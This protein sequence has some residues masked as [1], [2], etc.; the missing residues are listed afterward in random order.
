MKI[1][2]CYLLLC[3]NVNNGDDIDV[4]DYILVV[5]TYEDINYINIY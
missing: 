2:L 4:F 3:I 1:S 5:F